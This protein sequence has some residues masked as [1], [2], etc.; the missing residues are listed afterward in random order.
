L[1]YSHSLFEAKH[2]RR[3]RVRLEWGGARLKGRGRHTDWS[4]Q[5]TIVGGTIGRATAYAF[6][7]PKQ[8]IAIVDGQRIAWTS[9]TSGDHDGILLDLENAGP[10]TTIH[11]QTALLDETFTLKQL[12]EGPIQREC[13]G[14]SQY[15]LFA[16]HPVVPG[17]QTIDFT[18]QD[19]EP[20]PGRNAYWVRVVQED[21]E[22]A[23][24]SPLYYRP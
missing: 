16:L 20:Q 19:P 15:A 23:W 14:V 8:G 24:S 1:A 4:G 6:D 22:T 9:T 21:G 3:D 17:P 13:G 5:A 7:H 10:G 11:F 18:W 2:Y 12:Q